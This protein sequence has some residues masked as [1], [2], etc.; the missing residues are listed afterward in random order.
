M[1]VE[2]RCDVN[3]LPI[4]DGSDF[5]DVVRSDKDVLVVHIIVPK[6]A[7]CDGSI[8]RNEPVHDLL[9]GFNGCPL[10]GGRWGIKLGAADHEELFRFICDGLQ[11]TELASC[12]GPAIPG[13]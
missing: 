10:L 12:H 11:S 9:I 1:V 6:M 4:N 2:K 7:G 8:C 3:R 13:G 5:G